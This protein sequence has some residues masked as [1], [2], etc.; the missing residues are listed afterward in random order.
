MTKTSFGFCI[1]VIGIALTILAVEGAF[2]YVSFD[3][4]INLRRVLWDS[5]VGFLLFLVSHILIS[6]LGNE[7]SF[8]RALGSVGLGSFLWVTYKLVVIT[9]LDSEYLA[10]HPESY[11]SH[12]FS[13]LRTLALLVPTFSVVGIVIISVL[14]MA[15]MRRLNSDTY[16]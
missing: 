16:R 3:A 5:V 4:E 9:V 2:A 14:R 13:V 12:A 11:D 8:L 1:D 6:N 10:T 7:R 15:L